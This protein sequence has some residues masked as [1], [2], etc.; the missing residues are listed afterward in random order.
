MNLTTHSPGEALPLYKKPQSRTNQS[1]N[2]PS[3][4]GGCP[5]KMIVDVAVMHL[6]YLASAP[7]KSDQPRELFDRGASKSGISPGATF[8]RGNV[9]RATLAPHTALDLFSV[10]QGA[11]HLCVFGTSQ[12]PSR[13]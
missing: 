13:L 3:P 8:R 6:V 7:S 5:R 4:V 12:F 9:K 11:L 10:L 2:K 1:E